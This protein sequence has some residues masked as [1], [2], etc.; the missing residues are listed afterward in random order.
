MAA[1]AP[2][3]RQDLRHTAPQLLYFVIASSEELA[4]LA[5]LAAVS[6]S[7]PALKVRAIT[8]FASVIF[9][10][11]ASISAFFFASSSRFALSSSAL[12]ASG[13]AGGAAFG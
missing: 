8:S 1:V 12:A 6:N 10:F 9:L 5:A 4:L 13:T 3:R 11:D 2:D 7:L